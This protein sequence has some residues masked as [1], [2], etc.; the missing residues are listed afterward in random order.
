MPHIYSQSTT[1]HDKEEN[2]GIVAAF[3]SAVKTMN[4]FHHNAFLE[5]CKHVDVRP[6]GLHIRKNSFIQFDSYYITA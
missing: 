2:N 6:N 1:I 4:Y 3:R 5:Y